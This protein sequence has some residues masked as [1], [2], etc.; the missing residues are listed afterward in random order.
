MRTRLILSALAAVVAT[1]LVATT[2]AT[3]ADAQSS[4]YTTFDVIDCC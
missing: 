2:N 4:P 3:T 1:V